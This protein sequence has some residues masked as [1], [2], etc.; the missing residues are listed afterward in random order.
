MAKT[1]L[2]NKHQCNSCNTKFYD[3][4][5]EVPICPKC[6]EEIIIKIKPR[7]GRPPRNKKPEIKVEQTK[8]VSKELL[9]KEDNE[10]LDEELD[11]LVSMEDLDESIINSN[12][13]LTIENENEDND[14]DNLS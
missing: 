1:E 8:K 3:L 11:D 10:E 13:D 14:S 4:Q 6:G 12:N 2:G 7:L 9:V 5:K